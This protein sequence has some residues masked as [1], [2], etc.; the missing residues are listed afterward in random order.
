MRTTLLGGLLDT[1]RYNLAHGA[2]AVALAESGRVYLRRGEPLASGALGGAFAG[3]LPAPAYEPWRIGCLEAGPQPRGGWR[4]EP[5]DP[6]YYALKAALEALA[7]QLGTTVEVEAA[8]EPF[9]HP[10]RGGRIMIGEV[11]AGWIGELHPLVCREWDVDRASAFELD[12]AP[13]IEAS[14][15]GLEQYVD[16]ISYPAV[17]QDIAVVVPETVEAARVVAAVASGGGELLRSADVFDLYHGEQVGE[18]RKSLALRLSFQAADRTLT[19][20]E[21]A[22]LRQRIATALSEIGGKLRE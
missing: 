3:E 19:D 2:E 13:L 11:G 16:V 6:D 4:G 18:G 20:D 1:A 5:T 17:H 9:L 15:S 12:L 8:A 10:G 7:A 14:P 22:D 21:V